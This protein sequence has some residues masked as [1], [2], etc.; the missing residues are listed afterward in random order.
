MQKDSHFLISFFFFLYI[1]PF[2]NYL[3]QKMLE[4][5]TDIQRTMLVEQ[6][7]KSIQDISL[8]MHGTR[9]VQRMIELISLDEQVRSHLFFFLIYMT[10]SSLNLII[11]YRSKKLLE[12]YHL[13]WLC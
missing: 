13:L 1:D 8:N 4:H 6:V 9:A 7:S 2:G 12:H 5:C 10:I 11:M 3:C